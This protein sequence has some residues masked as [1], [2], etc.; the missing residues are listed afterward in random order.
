MKFVIL[1]QGKAAPDKVEAVKKASVILAHEGS[2]EPGTIFYEIYQ[3][4]DDPTLFMV[5]AI[6]ESEAAWKTHV[7]SDAHA[8]F[9]KS[10]PEDTWEVIPKRTNLK[11]L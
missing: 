11:S 4:E 7:E 6:F 10:L 3:T 9:R 8:Q 5:F 1:T 2:N